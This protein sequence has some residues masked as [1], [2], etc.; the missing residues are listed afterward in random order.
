LFEILE[1]LVFGALDIR[2][3]I[4][5]SLGFRMELWKWKGNI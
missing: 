5:M 1:K 4:S 3:I 2:E